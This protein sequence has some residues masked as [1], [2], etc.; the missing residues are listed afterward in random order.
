M[1]CGCKDLT[2]YTEFWHLVVFISSLLDRNPACCNHDS[3]L[4]TDKLI[5]IRFRTFSISLRHRFSSASSSGWCW[6]SNTDFKCLFGVSAA[7]KT[8]RFKSFLSVAY[9]WSGSCIASYAQW[10]RCSQVVGF[11]K[12]KSSLS[13]FINKNNSLSSKYRLF[14]K[15]SIIMPLTLLCMSEITLYDFVH[16]MFNISQNIHRLL[17]AQRALSCD[18]HSRGKGKLRVFLINTVYN[19]VN[20][21][22]FLNQYITKTTRKKLWKKYET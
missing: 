5:E 21:E 9:T 6:T 15:K 7:F 17:K 12:S 16:C 10:F 4:L 8:T 20:F 13:Y 11:C 2:C 22:T 3:R 18:I 1:E 19:V 14:I